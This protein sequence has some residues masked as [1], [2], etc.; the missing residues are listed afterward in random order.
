MGN[1]QTCL[2]VGFIDNGLYLNG[3][4]L[5]LKLKEKL[6][7]L[8]LFF[9]LTQRYKSWSHYAQMLQRQYINFRVLKI[10]SLLTYLLST[11]EIDRMPV[12]AHNS[13]LLKTLQ[14]VIIYCRAE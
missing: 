1:E 11:M 3:F 9:S 7:L 8:G 5:Y 14:D 12:I 6:F 4:C 2:T 10:K 13:M